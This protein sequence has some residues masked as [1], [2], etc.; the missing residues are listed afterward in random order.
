MR[1]Q[2]T[3]L[4]ARG[5]A[6]AR[7][8][9]SHAKLSVSPTVVSGSRVVTIRGSTREVGDATTAIGKRLARRQLRTLR[10]T[11]K[12]TDPASSPPVV[13]GITKAPTSSSTPKASMQGAPSRRSLLPTPTLPPVKPSSGSPSAVQPSSSS[14]V[15]DAS[16]HPRLA[17]AMTAHRPKGQ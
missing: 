16:K 11:K 5:L 12:K 9:T 3:L 2:A 17:A 1:R 14:T 13:A 10:S 8:M 4:D 7:F 6:F 15:I